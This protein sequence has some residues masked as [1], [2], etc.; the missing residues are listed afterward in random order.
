LKNR[1]ADPFFGIG[2]AREALAEARV[3]NP[4][5]EL[6]H[7]WWNDLL[8]GPLDEL[9]GALVGEDS[10]SI[11]L[12]ANSPFVGARSGERHREVSQGAVTVTTWSSCPS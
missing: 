2:Q 10:H 11:E 4:F 6:W 1:P 7:E 3:A 9:I 5:G 8:N 12:R